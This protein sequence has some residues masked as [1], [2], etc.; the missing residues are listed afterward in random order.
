MDLSKS[1]GAQ[2][3]LTAQRPENAMSTL[4]AGRTRGQQG[5]CMY[6]K[7]DEDVSRALNT[8]KVLHDLALTAV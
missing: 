5:V 1:L 8:G 2:R 7:P 3:N 6:M 4:W